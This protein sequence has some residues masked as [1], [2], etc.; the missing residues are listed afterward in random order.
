MK[1]GIVS[2]H[3]HCKTHIAALRQDGYDVTC[4]GANPTKIPPSYEALIVR[5][6][7]SSHGG[8]DLARE[9]GRET[10]NPLIYEDGLSGIRRE[11]EALASGNGPTVTEADEAAPVKVQNGSVAADL[12]GEALRLHQDGCT[13][14]DQIEAKLLA[15]AHDQWGDAHPAVMNAATNMIKAIVSAIPAETKAAEEKSAMKMIIDP[16]TVRHRGPLPTKEPWAKRLRMAKFDTNA[17]AVADLIRQFPEALSAFGEVFTAYEDKVRHPE[18]IPADSFGF[19][20][21]LTEAAQRY[22]SEVFEALYPNVGKSAVSVFKG[23]PTLFTLYAM[24][25]SQTYRKHASGETGVYVPYKRAY[26]NAY[27]ALTGRGLESAIVDQAAWYLGLPV[28]EASKRGGSRPTRKVPLR[29]VTR[30]IPAPDKLLVDPERY[31]IKAD[32]EENTR[33]LLELMDTV[34]NLK[35]KV[36]ALTDVVDILTAEDRVEVTF[37]ERA[38]TGDVALDE[39]KSRLASMGFKGTLTLNIE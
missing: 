28:P 2:A 3:K 20:K 33:A 39:I 14:P 5:V 25:A 31:K 11:L 29:E 9:W 22:G 30:G 19:D 37:P 24:C 15:F 34:A 36:E 1:I 23:N 6:A 16:T 8:T 13:D 12:R 27:E 26:I 18:A 10:G 4:L 7:S 21:A 17:S 38:S 32:V 35:A